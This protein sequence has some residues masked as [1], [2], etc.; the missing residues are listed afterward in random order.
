[1]SN[2]RSL[3]CLAFVLAPVWCQHVLVSEYNIA[4]TGAY[5]NE[6]TLAPGNVTPQGFGRLGSYPVD[7]CV[8]AHPLYVQGALVNNSTQPRNVVFILTTNASIYAYNAD[9]PY[10]LLGFVQGQFVNNPNDSDVHNC[11]TGA[12]SGPTGVLGT[13]AIDFQN[14]RLWYLLNRNTGTAQYILV[15]FDYKTFLNVAAITLQAPGFV[16]ANLLQ[17]TGVLF[18]FS[19]PLASVGFS[20][21]QDA[22]PWQGWVFTFNTSSF[23]QQAAINLSPNS[24]TSGAGVWMSG[25]GISTD[26]NS[27]YFTTGNLV[28]PGQNSPAPPEYPNSIVQMPQAGTFVQAAYSVPAA[29]QQA[30]NAS[31]LDLGSSRA[32]VVPNTPYVI[33]GSKLGDLFI[34]ANSALQVRPHVCPGGASVWSFYNGFALWNND[35]YTWC[36]NDRLKRFHFNDLLGNNANPLQVGDK[37]LGYQGANLAVS[38]N[39]GY[40]Q[41]NGLN[42]IVWATYPDGD[43]GGFGGGTLAAYNAQ[44]L[45]APIYTSHLNNLNFQK[46]TPPVIANG[47]VYVATASNQVLIYGLGGQNP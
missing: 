20:S 27:I 42:G 16:P 21:H 11:A 34:V 19:Q 46:F 43:A 36:T 8:Y 1:M 32:I 47:K 6:V 31:D 44:N 17:R 39:N 30:W 15:G 28:G 10:N 13:P 38:G 24:G 9:A 5:V 25:G 18:D 4:R 7:N 35:V 14:H 45:T 41:A 12:S 2:Q 29:E 3:L 26:G 40:N 23:F 22:T 33:A 37:V